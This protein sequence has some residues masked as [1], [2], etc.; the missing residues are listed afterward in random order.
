MILRFL[1]KRFDWALKPITR[2]YL[3][4][5][6]SYSFEEIKI[7]IYPTVFHPG[8]FYSTKILIN[9]LK[10]QKLKNL[11]IL[12]LGA[13]SGLI[14]IYAAKRNADV[15]AS[16]INPIAIENLKLNATLNEVKI[17][18]VQSDLFDAL[19]QTDF[20][21]III[22]P[23]YYPKNILTQSDLA[24]YCGENFEYFKKLFFQLNDR[25]NQHCRCLMILSE[26]CDL[27]EIS[28]LASKH[29]LRLKKVY[30]EKGRIENNFV[31][32]ITKQS[33]R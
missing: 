12:E 18:I 29:S 32:E 10:Q 15:T 8:L 26:D 28:S 1:F 9:Y 22:N 5:E 20:S 3:A 19:Y 31:F 21:L 25:L 6:R 2:W 27:L 24:W 13:G 33:Q 14:S 16:D 11:K 30:E 4:K 17:E 7:K 23:P